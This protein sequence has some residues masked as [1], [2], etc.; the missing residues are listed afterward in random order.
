MTS[1]ILVIDDEEG[2]RDAFVLALHGEPDLTVETAE[3]G[4]AG[5]A[6]ARRARPDLV[7]LDLNM[8]GM[9]G[10]ET[11]HELLAEDPT[12]SIYIVTAFHQEFMQDLK[13]ARRRGL[14][15]ELARKP[16][17]AEQI[18]AIVHALLQ[19][20]DTADTEVEQ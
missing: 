9:T 1:R 19:D 7:F 8:P 11:M 12:L 13:A 5:H 18:R 16:L 2:V 4:A 20:T 6:A 14:T 10:I 3:N 17:G 15:F